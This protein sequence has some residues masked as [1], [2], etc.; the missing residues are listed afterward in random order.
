MDIKS[1]VKEIIERCDN[2]EDFRQLLKD[3]FGAAVESCGVSSVEEF[4]KALD[5][6]GLMSDEEMSKVS[7]G[8]GWSRGDSELYRSRSYNYYRDS[9]VNWH[10]TRPGR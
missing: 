7:G 4:A 8:G 6:S 5:E 1:K 10:R 3:D 2:D 9:Y